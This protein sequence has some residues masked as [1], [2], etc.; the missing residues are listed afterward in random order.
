MERDTA[1]E[2]FSTLEKNRRA[3][4]DAVEPFIVPVYAVRLDATVEPG[5]ESER[6]FT[7]RVTPLRG[8]WLNRDDWQYVLE[9]ASEHEVEVDLQNAGMELR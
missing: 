8:G 2:I 7:V 3:I 6:D 9:V 1:L 4:D 5:D